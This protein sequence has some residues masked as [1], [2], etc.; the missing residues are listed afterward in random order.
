MFGWPYC[1][2]YRSNMDDY[3][4]ANIDEKRWLGSGKKAC[5]GEGELRAC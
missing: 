4:V 3:E 1:G 5:S 2:D